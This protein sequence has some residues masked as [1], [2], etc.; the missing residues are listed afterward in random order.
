M[1]LISIIETTEP[2]ES[3]CVP[4]LR[5]SMANSPGALGA[6]SAGMGV[7]EIG[8]ADVPSAPKPRPDAST[9][10]P[11]G[12]MVELV[13]SVWG[14]GPDATGRGIAGVVDVCDARAPTG[15]ANGT[16]N[17]MVRKATNDAVSD[18]LRVRSCP[19][20]RWSSESFFE[21]IWT[22]ESKISNKLTLNIP[23]MH[24]GTP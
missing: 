11:S 9:P 14:S 16:S 19:T 5:S 24:R 10:D 6:T 2:R 15:A 3:V 18:R 12:P 1:A 23:K 20:V 17:M 13:D 21:D 4:R 22:P 7:P 8:W